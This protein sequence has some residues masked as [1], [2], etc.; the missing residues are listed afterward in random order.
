MSGVLR[1]Q[2]R[3]SHTREAQYRLI[4]SFQQ[5][6]DLGNHFPVSSLLIHTFPDVPANLKELIHDKKITAVLAFIALM[7]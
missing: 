7:F 6:G 4:G 3:D 1:K 2:M 5:F